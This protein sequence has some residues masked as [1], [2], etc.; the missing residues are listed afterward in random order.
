[1]IDEKILK[2]K[3]EKYLVCFNDQC[4]KHEH[5]LRWQVGLYVPV[6]Q[7]TIT[8]VNPKLK[9]SAKGGCSSF[10]EDQIKKVA[11]G[12]V[13][14]YDDMPRKLEVAIK[15]ELIATFTRVGYYDMRKGLR[16]ITSDL[17]RMIR[18]VCRNHGWTKKLHFDDYV[19]ELIW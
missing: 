4:P 19:D 6:K 18:Q 17:E 11:K 10:R 9:L 5:C 13:H 7:M 1:M 12:M 3:A 2:Q 14:F 8:C 16:P 15:T